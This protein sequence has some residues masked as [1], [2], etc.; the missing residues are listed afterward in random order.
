MNHINEIEN[1]M[2]ANNLEPFEPTHPGEVVK[3][4][5]E[6]RGISQRQL[7]DEI[8]VSSSLLNEV[9]NGKRTMNTQLALLISAALDIDVEPL[10]RLQTKYDMIMAKRNKTFM[11]RMKNVR[12]IAAVL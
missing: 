12:K 8:G 3:D 10:L 7:A 5:I 11:Q 4:E 2:T 6:Y 9:L 1:K